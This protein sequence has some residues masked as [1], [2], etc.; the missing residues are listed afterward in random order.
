MGVWKRLGIVLTVV[1]LLGATAFAVTTKAERYDSVYGEE[2][3]SCRA[4]QGDDSNREF[5][6][7]QT[8]RV[9]GEFPIAWEIFKGAGFA[10]LT[11]ALF[12]V[13]FASVWLPTRWILAGRKEASH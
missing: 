9:L 8:D 12:W 6:I 11:A 10:V 2:F 13:L 3:R 5:C 1:W 4:L 7:E